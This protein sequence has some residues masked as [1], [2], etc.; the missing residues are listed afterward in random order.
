YM[1]GLG[2]EKDYTKA[3]EWYKKSA[4]NGNITAQHNIGYMYENG[5]GVEKDPVKAQEWYSKS[6]TH[7]NR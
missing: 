3:M 4:L 2:V 6:N 5:L 1:S 7:N